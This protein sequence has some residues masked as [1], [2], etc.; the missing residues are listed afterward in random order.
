MQT[1][2]TVTQKR[3]IH[4]TQVTSWLAKVSATARKQY[5]HAHNTFLTSLVII[6]I[7]IGLKNQLSQV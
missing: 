7:S 5:N 3:N 6:A 4:L 2:L 1:I